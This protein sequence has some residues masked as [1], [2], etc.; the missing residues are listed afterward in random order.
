MARLTSQCICAGDNV[1]ERSMTMS[2]YKGPTVLEALEALALN[3]QGV[4][5][6][7]IGRP[8]RMIVQRV[9]RRSHQ[10]DTSEVLVAGCIVTGQLTVG[11]R[12]VIQPSNVGDKGDVVTVES[13]HVHHRP[14]HAVFGPHESVALKLRWRQRDCSTGSSQARREEQQLLVDMIAR[15]SVIGQKGDN[16]PRRIRSFNAQVVMLYAQNPYR[17]SYSPIVRVH[18]AAVPCSMRLLAKVRAKSG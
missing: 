15:G 13:I 4:R 12:V 16:Q 6:S 7:H 17:Q 8:A 18:G 2:W 10:P 11:D 1:L 5:L 3:E 14:R 9:Y